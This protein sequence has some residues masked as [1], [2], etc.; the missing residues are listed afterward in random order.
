MHLLVYAGKDVCVKE[1]LKRINCNSAKNVIVYLDCH[2]DAVAFADAKTTRERY[3]IFKTVLLYCFL[4]KFNDLFG[5][6]QVAGGTDAYL[7][8]HFLLTFDLIS[9]S[10]NSFIVSGVTE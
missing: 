3:L 9:F 1:V 6:F 10:K 8:N 4:H 7:D 5:T 2:A